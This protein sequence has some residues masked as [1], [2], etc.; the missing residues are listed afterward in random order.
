MTGIQVQVFDSKCF[1]IKYYLRPPQKLLYLTSP[2]LV[3]MP[4]IS[5][6][7]PVKIRLQYLL[8]HT[9]LSICKK[10]PFFP[11]SGGMNRFNL[12]CCTSKCQK[13]YVG[14]RMSGAS[15][16]SQ[17]RVPAHLAFGTQCQKLHQDIWGSGDPRENMYLIFVWAPSGASN[18]LTFLKVPYALMYIFIG[19]LRHVKRIFGK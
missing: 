8:V 3:D 19:I 11:E 15:N 17:D 14:Y 16:S 4:V 13:I 12:F 1:H 7:L 9:F 6:H 10:K 5:N 18:K 2:Q